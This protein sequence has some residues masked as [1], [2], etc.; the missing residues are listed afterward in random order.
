MLEVVYRDAVV[1]TVHCTRCPQQPL[2]ERNGKIVFPDPRIDQGEVT[3]HD[4]AVYRV[5]GFGLQF[6]RPPA[7][8]NRVGFSTGER[9]EPTEVGVTIRVRRR[10]RNCLFKGWSRRFK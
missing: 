4:G 7:L 6:A 5:P 10:L 9:I 1:D 8:A 2:Y 3:A